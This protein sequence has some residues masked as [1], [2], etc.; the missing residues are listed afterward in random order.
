MLIQIKA[1]I[2]KYLLK[3]FRDKLFY[4]LVIAAFIYIYFVSVLKFSNIENTYQFLIDF[5][6]SGMFNI[7]VILALILGVN[8]VRNEIQTKS[9]YLSLA[10]PVDR[11]TFLL[12]KLLG[13]LIILLSYV[14]IIGIELIFLVGKTNPEMITNLIGAI[15]LVFIKLAI[16]SSFIQMLSLFLSP[17]LNVA[18]TLLISIAG[19]MSMNYINFILTESYKGRGIFFIKLIKF[20]LPGFEFFSITEALLRFKHISFGY[21]LEVIIYGIL[22]I[23][24]ILMISN[25]IFREKN[26]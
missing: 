6:I 2:N 18:L 17:V 26:L 19:H 5:S 23:L 15:L 11:F 7:G 9:I 13:I 20:I 12:G 24:F 10:K 14:S 21:Y 25:L 3:A 4:A 1:I 8:E 16:I 22:Y